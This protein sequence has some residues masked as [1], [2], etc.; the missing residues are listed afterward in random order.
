MNLLNPKALRHFLLL[1]FAIGILGLALTHHYATRYQHD[2]WQQKLKSQAAQVSQE[3]DYE[4]AKFEQIPNLLS[5]DPR[6]LEAV[7]K[8]APSTELNL[9]LAQ[10]LKQSLADTIYVHDK[11]GLVIAS[12][13]YQQAD[14]FVGS[15]FS[16]RPYFKNAR[17]GEPAQYVGLGVRSNKRGYFFSSPLWLNGDVIGVITVKVNLE[18]L[19]QRL[20]QSGSDVL[21]TDKHNVV[22]MSNLPDWRYRALF[23]LSPTAINELT[24]TRQY[25]DTLPEYYGELTAQSDESEFADNQLLLS[26]NYLAYA[27]HLLDKGF[28]VVALINH[29]TVLTAVLQADVVYLI[30]YAL[31]ALIALAWF[32]MLVNKARLAN[33]NVS[34]EEKVM[35]RTVVLSEAN[36]KLQQTVRQYEQSQQELRQTQQELTQAA[37]LALLGELS[38]SINHEINQPLAAL[39]T[40]TENSQRLLSMERYPMVADNLNKMLSLNET[41]AEVIARLKV[42]TRKTSH[43]PHNEVS[44]LH[45]AVHN[46]T[47]ILSNKLIKQ[48]VTLK[49]PTIDHEVRLAIHSVELEQ[50]LINLFHN[51]AQAMDGYCIDPQISIAI[52]CHD[53][54]CDILVSDNGP[55]MSDEALA[56]IFDPFF[57][58]KP[59]GLGLGLTISKRILESYHGALSAY[60]HQGAQSGESGGMTFVV[61]VPMANTRTTKPATENDHA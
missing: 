47:S 41:I 55:G 1:L 20:A 36:H 24:E 32:Q 11:T 48:G 60:N 29:H 54:S 58:T 9:L 25:G 14:T 18:Q 35:Q 57:T 30:L 3:V 15:S 61:T 43:E 28:R 17:R 12:S 31:I 51:A 53:S 52:Q 2:Q 21:V 5:H 27:T 37:K 49:V 39:R 59:E 40:Y 10:W 8:G 13:N 56:K 44:I 22:F 38:A 19:E 7:E 4:L 23:P 33:L 42:F 26:P 34:L 50:V 6:L 46:A 45:D 16:Y